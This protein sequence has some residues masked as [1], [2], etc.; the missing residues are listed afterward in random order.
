VTLHHQLVENK[1]VY[2]RCY[3]FSSLLT[4]MPTV[5]HPPESHSYSLSRQPRHLL[6]TIT[7]RFF[8]TCRR[9]FPSS[10]SRTLTH[11]AYCY[12]F[13]SLLTHMPTVDHPPESHSYSL[14]RQPRHLLSTITL[15]FFITCRRGFPS[16]LSRTL[17][18]YA[19]P[20]I[21]LSPVSCTILRPVVA[22]LSQAFLVFKLS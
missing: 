2:R 16:S 20:L 11:Y 22:D 10:L 4:H 8:I 5:D 19:Y 15:R 1:Q 14:S 3:D 6:S 7:L 9:G 13:S 18:H 12:D 17:T 21:F